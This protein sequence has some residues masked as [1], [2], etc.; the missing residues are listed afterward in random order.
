MIHAIDGPEAMHGDI[1][2]GLQLGLAALLDSDVDFWVKDAVG[3]SARR[4]LDDVAALGDLKPGA[5]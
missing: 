4:F 3:T 5:R 1:L 2:G